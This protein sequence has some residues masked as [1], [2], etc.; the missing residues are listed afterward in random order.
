MW[1]PRRLPGVDDRLTGREL[2][3]GLEL[4][5]VRLYQEQRLECAKACVRER[6]LDLLEL[7]PGSQ[8]GLS[9]SNPTEQGD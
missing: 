7:L 2:K 6:E 1:V 5:G 3:G 8:L 4:P 9:Q